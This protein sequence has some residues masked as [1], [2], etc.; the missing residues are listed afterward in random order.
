MKKK[1]VLKNKKGFTLVELLV[2]T[3]LFVIIMVTAISS[4]L[5]ANNASKRSQALRASMDN[6]NFA[7]EN[8]TR[9]MKLGSSYQC[10]SG[11]NPVS[12]N[13]CPITS[14]GD[15]VQFVVNDPSNDT[16]TTYAY[17]IATNGTYNY[18]AKCTKVGS[19][20]SSCGQITSPELSITKFQVAISGASSSDGQPEG[21]ITIEGQSKYGNQTV[22]FKVQ[23][24]VT[25]RQLE[26]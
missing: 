23:T 1:F 15:G 4:L 2:A 20:S 16:Q 26:S 8:I 11:G 6:L 22:P 10:M 14:P 5:S 18:I 17:S 7:L 3:A 13:N 12:G 24:L 21:F 9:N 19:G 25:Q